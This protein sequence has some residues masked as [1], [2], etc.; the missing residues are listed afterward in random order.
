MD[1]ESES[2]PSRR[3]NGGLATVP[4]THTLNRLLSVMAA[5][6]HNTT[7]ARK[8]AEVRALSLQYKREEE[9]F[10]ASS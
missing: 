4:D 5:Q 9:E 3:L 6:A 7:I 2:Q 10:L 8:N 1:P